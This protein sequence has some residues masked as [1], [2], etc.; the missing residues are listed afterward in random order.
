M[1]LGN[2]VPLVVDVDFTDI[3]LWVA[4]VLICQNHVLIMHAVKSAGFM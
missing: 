1:S 3:V 4:L 2:A